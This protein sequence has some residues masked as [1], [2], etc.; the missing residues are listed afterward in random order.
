MNK[1]LYPIT[2]D[3]FKRHLHPYLLA[4]KDGRRRSALISDYIF[5]YA[6]LYEMRTGISWRDL[7]DFYGSWHTMY[8]RFKRS[9]T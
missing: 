9:L 5:F 4:C 6:I 7:P 1:R 3:Y 2:E 8:T